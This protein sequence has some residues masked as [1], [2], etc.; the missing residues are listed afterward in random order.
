MDLIDK[1]R[2]AWIMTGIDFEKLSE[3]ESGFIESCEK[4]LA[5][6]PELSLKQT[7]ILERIYSEKGK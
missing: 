4:Q 1:P 6:K 2:F 3:W 7:E 5:Y